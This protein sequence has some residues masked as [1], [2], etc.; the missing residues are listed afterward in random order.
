MFVSEFVSLFV[1]LYSVSGSIFEIEFQ[2]YHSNLAFVSFLT[3]YQ[4]SLSNS[5]TLRYTDGFLCGIVTR[6]RKENQL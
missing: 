1:S 4:T 5:A 3:R 6:S 2:F